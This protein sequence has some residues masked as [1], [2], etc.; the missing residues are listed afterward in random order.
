MHESYPF[1]VSQNEQAYYP[2]VGCGVVSLMMF[3]K[4]AN[5][6]QH[7]TWSELCKEHNLTTPPIKKGYSQDDPSVGLYPEVLFKYVIKR[8]L[9]FRMHFLDDEWKEC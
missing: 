5:L 2:E 3:L 8:G 7:F 9:H 6:A 1:F 4:E